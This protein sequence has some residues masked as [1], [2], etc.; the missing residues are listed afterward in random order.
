MISPRHLLLLSEGVKT[1]VD[2]HVPRPADYGHVRGNAVKNRVRAQAHPERR[3]E[4]LD[5]FFAD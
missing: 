1:A 5:R 2:L 3:L 4:A